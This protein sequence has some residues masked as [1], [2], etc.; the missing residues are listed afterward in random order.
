[1]PTL[2]TNEHIASFYKRFPE[3]CSVDE[4]RVQMFLQDSILIMA[5]EAHWCGDIYPIALLYLTAHQMVMGENSAS[6][7]SGSAFPLKR[8]EVDDV[9]IESAVSNV[10]TTADPLYT[11][12]YGQQYAKYRRMCFAG[13]YGV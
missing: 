6:G 5:D 9:V 1:M 12:S 8:Q 3:F 11:T 4:D 13:L 2:T 7:D 10:D